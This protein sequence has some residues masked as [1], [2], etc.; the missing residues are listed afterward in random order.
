MKM[1]TLIKWCFKIAFFPVAFLWGVLVGL[2]AHGG[3]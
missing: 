2:I 1:F 3:R